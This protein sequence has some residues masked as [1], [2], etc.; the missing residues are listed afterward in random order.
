M[1]D[2]VLSVIAKSFTHELVKVDTVVGSQP[3][4]LVAEVRSHRPTKTTLTSKC[5]S[6]VDGL[7]RSHKSE[8]RN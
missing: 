6:L 4:F 7:M 2:E 5:V 3:T 1:A 8:G